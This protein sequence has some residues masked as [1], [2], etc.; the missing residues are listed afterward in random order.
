MGKTQNCPDFVKQLKSNFCFVRF[1]FCFH[2][3][4]VKII[5]I[6]VFIRICAHLKYLSRKKKMLQVKRTVLRNTPSCS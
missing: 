5:L 3:A 2:L 6:T 4:D 1:N